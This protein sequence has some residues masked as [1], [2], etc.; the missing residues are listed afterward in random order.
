MDGST[1]GQGT[2]WPAFAIEYYNQTGRKAAYMLEGESGAAMHYD[3]RTGSGN[4]WYDPQVDGNHTED[5]IAAINDGLSW[6]S[7]N[8]YDPTFRGILWHQGERDAQEIDNG[9]ITKTEFKNAFERMR[10]EFRTQLGMP[11]MPI[12]IHELGK[13]DSG[14]TGGFQDVRAAQREEARADADVHLVSDKQ[15]E[16]P[17]MG[18]MDDDVHYNQD[19]YN[20]MGEVGG[21]NVASRIGGTNITRPLQYKRGTTSQNNDYIGA[22]G[23]L[24]VDTDKNTVVVH[25]GVA[26]GGHPLAKE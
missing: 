19:G 25:D 18:Y 16:F 26:A 24:T 11:E 13:P 1:G 22:A 21:L 23:E 17:S 14:D 8:G 5:T 7:N 15:K 9:T 20:L 4:G 10:D 2:A 12:W 6:L 3:A